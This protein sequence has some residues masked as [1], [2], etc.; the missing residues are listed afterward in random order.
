MKNA[1]SMII[2]V[3]PHYLEIIVMFRPLNIFFCNKYFPWRISKVTILRRSPFRGVNFLK[4]ELRNTRIFDVRE[5][6]FVANSFLMRVFL[7]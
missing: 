7:H 3:F 6:L 4:G 2:T 1:Y 5:L